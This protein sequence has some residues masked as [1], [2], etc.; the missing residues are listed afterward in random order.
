MFVRLTFVKLDPKRLEGARAQANG[1]EI[2]EIAARE[3]GFRFMYLLESVEQPGDAVSI[4]AWDTR[5]D[6]EAYAKKIYPTLVGKFKQWFT[7]PA[8][9]RLYEAPGE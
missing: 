2:R 3:K 9:L 6:A 8:E 1:A 7:G 5:E 4:S